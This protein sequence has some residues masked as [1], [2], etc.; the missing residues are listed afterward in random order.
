MSPEPTKVQVEYI[1]EEKPIKVI[2][3]KWKVSVLLC[4]ISDASGQWSRVGAGGGRGE[5]GP[6]RVGPARPHAGGCDRIASYSLAEIETASSYGVASHLFI[7]T[8][9]SVYWNTIFIKRQQQ[10]HA[11]LIIEQNIQRDMILLKQALFFTFWSLD[12][13]MNYLNYYA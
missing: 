11:C 1:N 2:R 7:N 5:R 9:Q 4:N 12:E 10:H 8:T 13:F 3:T 6:G